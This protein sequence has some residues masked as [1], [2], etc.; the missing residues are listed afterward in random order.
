MTHSQAYEWQ[1]APWAR[2]AQRLADIAQELS[3]AG[4]GR[5]GEGWRHSRPGSQGPTPEE[6]AE[7]M[8]W[9]RMRGGPWF[10]GPNAPFGRGPRGRGRARR[11]DVRLA[12]LR[13][14]GEEPRNG[15]QLM[16]T[17]DERSG[18]RWSPSPGSIYPTLSQLED[19]GLIRSQERDGSRT[20]GLTDAGREHLQARA[21]EPDPWSEGADHNER[22][23]ELGPAFFAFAKAFWQ[24][25]SVGDESQRARAAQLIAQARRTLYRILADDEQA[26]AGEPPEGGGDA[27]PAADAEHPGG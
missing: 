27:G 5:R 19:E 24:V 11:G 26:A 13:L 1:G 3:R 4:C 8:S 16:Q 17:I 10:A 12:V 22:L 23:S 25:A 2:R 20:W 7:L 15:Y 14:L 9:R 21:A 6:L 18:G